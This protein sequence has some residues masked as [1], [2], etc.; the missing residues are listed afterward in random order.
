VYCVGLGRKHG[1]VNIVKNEYLKE[2][3]SIFWNCMLS[4]AIMASPL[5]L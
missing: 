3:R 5:T 2:K 4:K 1:I